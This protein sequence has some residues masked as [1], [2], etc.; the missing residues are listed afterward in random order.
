MLHKDVLM[1]DI[2]VDQWRNAQALLLRSAKGARRL[3]VIHEG[4]RV[5]KFRHTQGL[6]VTGQVTEVHDPH[7]LARQLYAANAGAVDF[8]VVMERDAVD[9]YFAQIQ[10]A[11]DIDADLDVFVQG[12]YA[13]LDAYPDGIVAYPG[14]AR[15]T[16]GL[17]WRIGASLEEV[18]TAARAFIAPGTTA[19]LGVHDG[20]SL[21]TSLVLDFD[22]DWKVTSITTADPSLINIRGGRVEVLERLLAWVEGSGK[23]VSL[24]LMMDRAAAEEFLAASGPDK[25]AAFQCLVAQDQLSV[26]RAPEALRVGC[27]PPGRL[28]RVRRSWSG[29]GPG[30]NVDPG[31]LRLR[32]DTAAHHRRLWR[33]FAALCARRPSSTRSASSAATGRCEP[34]SLQRTSWPSEEGVA[35]SVQRLSDAVTTAI[36]WHARQT[37]RL[38]CRRCAGQ[39]H[40]SSSGLPPLTTV[41]ASPARRPGS[42]SACPPTTGSHETTRRPRR[43]CSTW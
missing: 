25:P 13:A 24:A 18:N 9:S 3:V 2:D 36:D 21:W 26:G 29:Q 16:L 35:G 15:D 14:T 10:D 28:T 30:S 42:V 23:S 12:T 7:A 34:T 31:L 20:A 5:L 22:D 11:W 32:P 27:G 8:V 38:R 1:A 17:Q 43:G 41:R 39:T 40:L 6:T 19:I 37:R 33:R 4:G